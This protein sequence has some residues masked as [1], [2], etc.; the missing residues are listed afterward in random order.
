MNISLTHRTTTSVELVTPAFRESTDNRSFCAIFETHW[1]YVYES[2]SGEFSYIKSEKVTNEPIDSYSNLG[3]V[4]S[5][6]FIDSTQ[7]RFEAK[8]AKVFTDMTT[9]RKEVQP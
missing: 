2:Y 6:E 1:V 4:L 8:L 3:R 9:F 7:G 5:D